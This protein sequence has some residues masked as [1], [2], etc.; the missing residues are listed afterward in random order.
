MLPST[1][2]DEIKPDDE[3]NIKTNNKVKLPL[4]RV[5]RG[6]IKNH[7]FFPNEGNKKV[8]LS[9]LMII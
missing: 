8:L 2:N 4:L 3:F 5:G 7:V 1:K 9:E 6:V